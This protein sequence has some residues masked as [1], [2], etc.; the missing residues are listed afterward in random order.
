[1]SSQ[2]RQ[3]QSSNKKQRRKNARSNLQSNQLRDDVQNRDEQIQEIISTQ[4]NHE[5]T[6]DIPLTTNGIQGLALDIH[7]PVE[8]V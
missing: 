3:T 6:N 7:K 5:Q 8:D 4:N 1:M 2:G